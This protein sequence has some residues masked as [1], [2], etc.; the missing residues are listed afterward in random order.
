MDGGVGVKGP[1]FKEHLRSLNE[2]GPTL[3][4]AGPPK[5]TG[6]FTFPCNADRDGQTIRYLTIEESKI[7]Q[8]FP[9]WFELKENEYKFI[10]NSVCPPMAEAIGGHLISLLDSD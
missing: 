9:E 4:A 8:G 2:P 5:I 10:G 3:A 6:P 7:L 1:G